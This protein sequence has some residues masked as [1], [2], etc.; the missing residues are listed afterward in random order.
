MKKHLI[1]EIKRWD[2]AIDS[3]DFSVKIIR[4]NDGKM[5]YANIT[6]KE[7]ENEKILGIRN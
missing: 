5:L 7:F 4:D 3:D 2:K 6:P 1:V